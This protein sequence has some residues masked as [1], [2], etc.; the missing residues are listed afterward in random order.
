VFLTSRGRAHFLHGGV[1]VSG[2]SRFLMRFR[3]PQNP[4]FN[5]VV[6]FR[7]AMHQR[8]PRP[9]PPQIEGRIAA[10][11]FP[12]ITKTVIVEK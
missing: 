3:C 5:V 11:F 12:P 1:E 2:I 4:V 10:E 9:M 7:T 8:N 6:Q